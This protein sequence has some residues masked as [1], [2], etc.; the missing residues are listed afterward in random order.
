MHRFTICP[1]NTFPETQL[2]FHIKVNIA[3]W[4]N[5]IYDSR[6]PSFRFR[7]YHLRN[8]QADAMVYI[9][10]IIFSLIVNSNMKR[11]FRHALPRKRK[12]GKLSTVSEKRRIRALHA[13]QIPTTPSKDSPIKKG[14]R[15][16]LAARDFTPALHES[17]LA[18]AVKNASTGAFW[19]QLRERIQRD[20]QLSISIIHII[21]CPVHTPYSIIL[22][23]PRAHFSREICA[24]CAHFSREICAPRAH[25]PKQAEP[26][27]SFFRLNKY[28]PQSRWS[29]K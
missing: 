27:P 8:S 22:V 21:Q 1:E 5:Y 14:K 19:P 12:L 25:F 28:T 6:C 3:F 7:R 17:S 4:R 11:F 9:Y 2:L 15:P 20:I 16:H 29:G 18:L 23:K 13:Q 24:P 26:P 10:T